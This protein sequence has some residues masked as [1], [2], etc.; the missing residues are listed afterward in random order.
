MTRPYSHSLAHDGRAHPPADSLERAPMLPSW[1]KRRISPVQAA[2][3]P[4]GAFI[5][6]RNLQ[7]AYPSPAGPV[8]ALKGMDIRVERGEFVAVIGKSGSGKSTF[9]NMLTG[10]D[11]P[12]AGEIMIGG[13]PIHALDEHAM[14][15]WRGR[16]LGIVFQFFQM[17]PTLTLLENI[18]LP[19]ELNG[20]YQPAERRK[21]AMHLLELVQLGD[22]AHKMP[23]AVSGGQQQRA[24]IAR[25]LANSPA[26]LIADEPTGSLDSRTA[27]Q[28]FELFRQLAA[29]GTTILMVTHDDD[30]ARRVDRAI[31]IADG[32]VVHEHLARAL[33]EIGHDGLVEVKRRATVRSYAPGTTIFRQGEVGREFF[34]LLEG[35][36]DVLVE[37]PGGGETLIDQLRAGQWFGEGALTGRGVRAATVRATNAAPVEVAALDA[38]GFHELVDS[39]PALH[40][41]LGQIVERNQI[42]NQLQA[43]TALDFRSLLAMTSNTRAQTFPPGTP[44]IQQGALG[45]TFFLLLEGSVDVVTR[46]SDGREKHLDRLHAGQFFG[47]LALLGDG[48][49]MASV[50]AADGPA[51]V[52]ELGRADFDRIIG[53][54]PAFR[55][56]LE[57]LALRRRTAGDAPPEIGP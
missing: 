39:S 16:N 40:D 23:A 12:S 27:G 5:E 11:R 55:E 2:A 20:L 53:T 14:A 30:L 31:L 57:K 37:R 34:I 10:I 18:V 26:L 33:K 41:R 1:I 35:E 15:E 8:L 22:H 38:D 46:Q 36:V 52:A 4:T 51:R 42:R 32:E 24:A 56:Q 54:S 29:E 9:I 43:L 21:R 7:K 17:L 25:A 44:I 50:R 28:I 45:D 49:R 13:T 47:E 48:R 19:M 6:V 3:T